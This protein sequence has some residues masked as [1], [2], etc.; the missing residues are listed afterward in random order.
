MS[1]YKQVPKKPAPVSFVAAV[2]SHGDDW[3]T[4]M[5]QRLQPKLW[6]FTQDQ[7]DAAHMYYMETGLFPRVRWEDENDVT[8]YQP[9]EVGEYGFGFSAT[10]VGYDMDDPIGVGYSRFEAIAALIEAEQL[11]DDCQLQ[12]TP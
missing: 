1:H 4:G 12:E 8:S 10:R 5:S 11:R 3:H 6:V 9:M 2:K 7:R